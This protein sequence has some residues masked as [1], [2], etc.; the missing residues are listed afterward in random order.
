MG[1][2]ISIALHVFAALLACGFF[3][4]IISTHGRITA[5][6]Y[7]S[8]SLR[9]YTVATT[10]I[11]DGRLLDI[12]EGRVTDGT[13]P[14]TDDRASR[15][16]RIAYAHV[17]AER[18][19]LF[20]IPGTA[21]TNLSYTA[22]ELQGT[23]DQLAAL[24][25][26]NV[27]ATLVRTS[28]YPIDFLRTAAVA[29]AARAT[30]IAYPDRRNQDRYNE[31][32]EAEI[33][34]YVF[35]LGTFRDGVSLAVPDSTD[36]YVAAGKVIDKHGILSAIDTLRARIQIQRLR[37]NSRM[38]CIGGFVSRCEPEDL[39]IPQLHEPTAAA[40]SPS[41]VR[42]ASQIR[43]IY[44]NIFVEEFPAD[45]VPFH[46]PL[47][48]L[49][50]GICTAEAPGLPA[51][52]LAQITS[53]TVSPERQRA[54]YVGNIRFIK[55]STY[56]SLPFYQ[57]LAS[58]GIQYVLSIPSLQYECMD[59]ARDHAA[60]Y[61]T[62]DVLRAASSSADVLYQADAIRQAN[63]M[64][65]MGIAEGVTDILSLQDNSAHFDFLVHG[66]SR[67]ERQNVLLVKG[68]VAADM[69]ASNLF[70]SRSGFVSLFMANNPSFVG[71][72]S[73]F[74]TVYIPPEQQPYSYY[75]AISSATER[76]KIVEDVHSYFSIH[77]HGLAPLP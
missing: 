75:S 48:I 31:A 45:G 16:L 25:D 43:T 40:H 47:I 57:N 72:V 58:M 19:P 44:E 17:L 51:Y 59:T 24:Q 3:I 50:S 46:S 18:N 74:D 66:I 37:F 28:L 38:L 8:D 14:V 26:D 11:V 6:Q 68:G 62:A 13:R 23:A 67:T 7:I 54:I 49:A 52:I 35:D 61:F 1:R 10:A 55:L 12:K 30:F 21:P 56:A 73:L 77:N 53:D 2:Q 4:S 42:Q 64:A 39:S 76:Q 32:V 69:Y 9:T 36:Q 33:S 22:D 63:Q 65:L 15:A 27:S 70:L 5:D 71:V 20:A 41:L 34:A 60:I 29:E